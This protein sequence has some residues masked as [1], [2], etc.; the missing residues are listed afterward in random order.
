[1]IHHTI[2]FVAIT[3]LHLAFVILTMDIDRIHGS[4]LSHKKTTTVHQHLSNDTAYQ[5]NTATDIKECIT[6][7]DSALRKNLSINF[8]PAIIKSGS[9]RLDCRIFVFASRCRGIGDQNTHH[10]NEA[11][12]RVFCAHKNSRGV[13][14]YR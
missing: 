12:V 7:M 2:S 8:E 13:V 14:L 11:H 3:T 10:T 1:M 5:Q 6:N 4:I 9:R